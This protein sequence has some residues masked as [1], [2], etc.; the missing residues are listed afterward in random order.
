MTAYS[1]PKVGDPE[2]RHTRSVVVY[3]SKKALD[4]LIKTDAMLQVGWMERDADDPKITVTIK[5]VERV[6]DY[7]TDT[8]GV[9]VWV[10]VEEDMLDEE[11]R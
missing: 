5:T 1:A 4:N 7:D 2:E 11:C 10:K 6:K 3:Y 8:V 9:M